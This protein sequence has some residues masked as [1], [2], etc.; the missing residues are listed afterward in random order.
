MSVAW[1]S[2]YY[3]STADEN[4][5]S[6]DDDGWSSCMAASSNVNEVSQLHQGAKEGHDNPTRNVDRSSRID[7][8]RPMVVPPAERSSG[9]VETGFYTALSDYHIS[10]TAAGDG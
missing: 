1:S 6:V 7:S 9:Q 10:R 5:E 8:Q 3:R 2:V 4:P